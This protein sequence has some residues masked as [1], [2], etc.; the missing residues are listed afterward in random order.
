M[1]PDCLYR[2]TDIQLR[3]EPKDW[4]AAIAREP[5]AF[6]AGCTE[7]LRGIATRTRTVRE[8]RAS[9]VPRAPESRMVRR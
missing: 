4:P 7:Y 2:A 1:T 6:R 8:A 9:Q 5:E 3:Y